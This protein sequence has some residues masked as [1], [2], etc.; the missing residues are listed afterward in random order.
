MYGEEGIPSTDASEYA[1]LHMCDTY[2]LK[3]LYDDLPNGDV[4]L[5]II[6][7]ILEDRG[8]EGWC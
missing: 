1:S 7:N 3:R 6:S 8:V 5:E 2:D 4:G